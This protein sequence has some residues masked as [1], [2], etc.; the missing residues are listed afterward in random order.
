AAA[1][2]KLQYI[3]ARITGQVSSPRTVHLHVRM[4]DAEGNTKHVGIA[5]IGYNKE[6]AKIGLVKAT[7]HRGSSDEHCN[8]RESAGLNPQTAEHFFTSLF[9]FESNKKLCNFILEIEVGVS[10]RI[11]I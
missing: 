6:S 5:V 8:N 2:R 4:R 9:Y 1:V 3:S 10:S 11:G 7:R